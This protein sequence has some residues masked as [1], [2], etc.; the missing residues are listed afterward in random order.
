MISSYMG[1]PSFGRILYIGMQGS[2]VLPA[3]VFSDYVGL[4]FVILWEA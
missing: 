3:S 1:I 2:C 4:V